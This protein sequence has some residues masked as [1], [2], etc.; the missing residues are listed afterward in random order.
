MLYGPVTPIGF[1]GLAFLKQIDRQ[2]PSQ[3]S[4]T[5]SRALAAGYCPLS[6][7][8]A[9]GGSQEFANTRVMPSSRSSGVVTPGTTSGAMRLKN[10]R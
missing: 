4:T 7:R 3:D 2:P 9:R 5:P 10:E 8:T 6:R 1:A